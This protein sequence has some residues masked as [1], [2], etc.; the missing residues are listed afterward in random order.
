MKRK[1]ALVKLFNF[2][3]VCRKCNIEKDD[4]PLVLF[5]SN[6]VKIKEM[7]GREVA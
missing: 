2:V 6:R 4:M 3:C 5:L 1:P 7:K